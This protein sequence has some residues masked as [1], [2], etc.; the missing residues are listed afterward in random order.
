MKT[1]FFILIFTS[2]IL[3]SQNLSKEFTGVIKLNDSSFIPYNIHL[4]SMDNIFITGTSVT[5]EGGEHETKSKISGSYD[6][7][8]HTLK[9]KE[10][11]I[12][13]SKSPYEELDFCFIHFEGKIQNFNNPKHIK[14]PFSGRYIDGSSCIDGEL[15][16]ADAKKMEQKIKKLK[17]KYDKSKFQKKF[18]STNIDSIKIKDITNGEDLNIFIKSK[19]LKLSIHDSGKIDNDLINLYIDDKLVL[20]N[21]SIQKEKKIIPLV[22]TKERMSIKVVAINEGTSSPNTVKV[23]IESPTD[24]ITTRTTLKVNEEAILSLVNKTF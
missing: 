24:Y 9:L 14:G 23:E 11:D 10:Y 13:Y 2:N 5:D 7:N 8:T 22:L 20:E 4:V 17:K 1:F 19:V 21:Y 6:S 18:K 12:I 15:L 16:L 3:F